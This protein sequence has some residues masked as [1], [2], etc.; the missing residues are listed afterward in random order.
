MRRLASL[1]LGLLFIAAAHAGPAEDNAD[2]C[3]KD[4]G[5]AA[6]EACTRA[7]QSGRFKGPVLATMFNNRAIEYRQSRDYD[8]AIADYSQAIRLD[9]DFPGAYAGRGLAY[10]GKS[11]IPK[12]KADYQ[13]ALTAPEKYDDGQWAHDVART[14]LSALGDKPNLSDKPDKPKLND[15]PKR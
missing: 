13:K 6:V 9:A 7:I 3:F 4:D 15:K 14:R 1:L 8:R 11:D 12:A 10:E 5:D 2:L